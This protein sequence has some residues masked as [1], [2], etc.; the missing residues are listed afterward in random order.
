MNGDKE[1]LT[2]LIVDDEAELRRSIGTVLKRRGFDVIEASNGEE[3]LRMLADQLPDLVVLD[4]KMP[5][6]TGI[7]TLRE[8][9]RENT[10]LPVL[11]LTG[12]GDFESALAG[13][14]LDVVDF[15]TKPVDPELLATRIRELFARERHTTLQEATIRELMLGPER[16]PRIYSDEPVTAALDALR[17]DVLEPASG[18]PQHKPVRSVLVYDRKE[19]FLGIIRLGDLLKLVLP[20]FLADSPYATYFT[21]MFLAQCK[22]MSNR[23]VKEL[24]SAPVIVDADAPLMQAV[25]LMVKHRLSNLPV[26]SEGKL[27]GVLR[28]REMIAEIAQHRE[29]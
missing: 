6:L 5:G 13:I 20:G 17:R 24:L 23:V 4:L 25:H 18:S 19:Q 15:V 27:I 16:Y 28:E 8:I 21:G 14:K 29:F 10:R 1:N 12:H 22:V 26:M 7:E 3:A 9:R 11:I 2:L